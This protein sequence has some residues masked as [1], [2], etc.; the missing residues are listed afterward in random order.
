MAALSPRPI[1]IGGH[2]TEGVAH[3]AVPE[4]MACEARSLT[5]RIVQC[6][7]SGRKGTGSAL[8]LALCPGTPASF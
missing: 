2:D 4:G 8:A 1:V 7:I 3:A 5:E 6:G